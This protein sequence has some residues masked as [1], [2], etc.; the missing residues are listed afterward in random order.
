ME[1][2]SFTVSAMRS[3]TI[4]NLKTN[5][6]EL[7]VLGGGATGAGIA[8][9]AASRGIKTALI[10]KSDFASGT[11][12]KS[13]KLIHGGLRYLKQLDVQLVRET[14][15]ER[16]ILHGLAPHLVLP[17]KMLMP[18]IKGGTYGYWS[19]S[20]GLKIYDILANVKGDDLSLIHI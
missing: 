4:D 11:S 13:S 8:L 19:T 3:Q 9:D 5:Q 20:F 2:S 18:L 17:E 16:A 15:T 6:F 10:E 12:S 14:G 1:Y 7:L